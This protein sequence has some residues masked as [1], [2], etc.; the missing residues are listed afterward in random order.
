MTSY[1]R[2]SLSF[3]T[4]SAALLVI[5][6][7]S[8]GKKPTGN[9]CG[10]IY[11]VETDL[12][13]ETPYMCVSY[14]MSTLTCEGLGLSCSLQG[15]GPPRVD[16]N[17]NPTCD[18][19]PPLVPGPLAT[20]LSAATLSDGTMVIAGYSPGH[21]QYE[22]GDLVYATHANAD[23]ETMNFE[24]S[25]GD[26][27]IVDGDPGT[28]IAADPASWRG[29]VRAPGDDVGTYNSIAVN[30]NDDVYVAY[31]DAT[32]KDLK[33][34]I[35]SGGTW[36]LSAVGPESDAATVDR[37]RWTSLAL[38]DSGA[39]AIAYWAVSSPDTSGGPAKPL[40][41]VRVISATDGTA[42]A[43]NPPVVVHQAEVACRPGYCAD[44]DLCYSNGQCVASTDSPP[45][46][47]STDLITG[48]MSC[49]PA[50]VVNS[51]FV[52]PTGLPPS[53]GLFNNLRAF[54]GGLALAFYN[55]SDGSVYGATSATADGTA[56]NAPFLIAGDGA[57]LGGDVGD[58]LD[59]YFD[60]ATNDWHMAYVDG[61]AEQ[62]LYARCNGTGA[63]PSCPV[64]GTLIDDGS[65]AITDGTRA[66]DGRFHVVGADASMV[67]SGTQLRLA[68]QDETANQA[69]MATS[70]DDGATWTI[71]VLDAGTGAGYFTSQVL[72]GTQS[73]TATLYID[74]QTPASGT[75]VLVGTSA[76]AP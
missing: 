14:D 23:M 50:T 55:R 8:C 11:C 36:T 67:L 41:S 60:T 5:S 35:N 76:P 53:T 15:S 71:T 46:V 45:D 16:A 10:D 74:Q 47:C 62:L 34:G 58:S 13:C 65:Y 39:P 42:T 29:G 75:R 30:G 48:T 69:V 28:P 72:F 49:T 31:Y 61:F 70:D 56:F 51:P 18:C 12:C 3:F 26:W 27:S 19:P 32:N 2:S 43:W 57:A 40:A 38:L 22:Y 4:L 66:D 54:P 17:C 7:C 52:E 6:G 1:L 9:P 37:G 59:M 44:S 21:P 63:T 20:F 64:V 33:L 24:L 73:Y 25:D 68:Y